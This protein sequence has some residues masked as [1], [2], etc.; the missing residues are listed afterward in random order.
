MEIGKIICL[1]LLY[2]HR[3]ENAVFV[4]VEELNW[5]LFVEYVELAVEFLGVSTLV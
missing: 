2:S 1:A 3:A 5:S 4:A